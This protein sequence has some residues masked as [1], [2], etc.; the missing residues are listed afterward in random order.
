MAKERILITGGSGLLGSNLVRA[1]SGA[2]DVYATYHSRPTVMPEGKFL[3]LDIRDEK[4]VLSVFQTTSPRL[5]I[6]TAALADVD[7]CE[8]Q[9]E[10]ARAINIQGTANV[11]RAS[12][13]IK[14]KLIH[15][16]TDSVFDGEKG[17]YR[18][19]D[20]PSPV[21]VYGQTKLEGEKRVIDLSSDRIIIRTAFYGRNRHGGNSLAEW[22]ITSLRNGNDINMFTDV[23]FSPIFLGDLIE[24]MIKMYHQN[25]TGIYHVGSREGCSKYDFGLKLAKGFG[26]DVT[27]IHPSTITSAGLKAPRPN[28]LSLDV[29]K[30]SRDLGVKLPG[31]EEG[32][33]RFKLQEE[34]LTSMT[35]GRHAEDK[36]R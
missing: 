7:E 36:N 25:L 5:V 10:A 18:E 9:P 22:V 28:N 34:K 15:I 26:L 20:T 27:K 35:G 14:A 23:F 12:Q 29:T 3:P 30:L 31:V 11:A 32:I 33:K 2:F 6:H 17:R 1:L 13:E 8:E 19:E 24:I 21:N 4:M 16:S